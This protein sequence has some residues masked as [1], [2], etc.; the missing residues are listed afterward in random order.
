MA[1]NLKKFGKGRQSKNVEDRRSA[2]LASTL[3]TGA[4][5][6]YSFNGVN[7]HVPGVSSIMNYINDS[8]TKKMTDPVKRRRQEKKRVPVPRPNPKRKTVLG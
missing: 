5:Y 2:G 8:D 6:D 3:Q 7:S 1:K 4:A